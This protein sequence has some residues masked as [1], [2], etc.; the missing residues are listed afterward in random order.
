VLKVRN[1]DKSATASGVSIDVPG[2]DPPLVVNSSTKVK[3]LNADLLDG[4]QASSF[5]TAVSAA[6]PN[7]T[8]IASMTPNGSTTC[9]GSTVY[10][11]D[12]HLPPNGPPPNAV[13][14]QPS[15]LIFGGSCTPTSASF[16]IGDNGAAPA[17]LSY[18]GDDG[19]T[20][21]EGNLEIVA[22][23]GGPAFL[24]ATQDVGQFIY[25]DQTTVATMNLSAVVEG[26]D[27]CEF[28]GTIDIAPRS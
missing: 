22:H 28:H 23:S 10:S 20:M 2:S 9:S 3:N 11:I 18:S 7:G 25:F 16:G 15:S 12:E 19:G 17:T 1:T 5:Q 8:A 6:C 21:Y 4:H 27:G 24:L 26:M 14:Y 13:T